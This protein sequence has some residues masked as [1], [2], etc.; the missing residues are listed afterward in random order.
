MHP[1]KMRPMSY[2]RRMSHSVAINTPPGDGI[3]DATAKGGQGGAISIAVP[4]AETFVTHTAKAY[5][6]SS[7]TAGGDV[8]ISSISNVRTKAYVKNGSGGAIMVGEADATTN[9][10]NYSKSFFGLDTASFTNYEHT[11]SGLLIRAGGIFNLSSEFRLESD[12]VDCI[13]H[14]GGILAFADADAYAN[15]NNFTISVIGSGADILADSV[16]LAAVVSKL[17]ADAYGESRAGG[18]TGKSRADAYVSIDT[19]ND[20]LVKAWIRGTSTANTLINATH[21]MDVLSSLSGFTL[22]GHKS[23]KFYGLSWGTGGSGEPGANDLKSYVDVDP[24]TTISVSPRST[25]TTPLHVVSGLGE[26]ALYVEGI[27]ITWDAN[28]NILGSANPVLEVDSTGKI[29]T[30]TDNITVKQGTTVKNQ[31]DT[32]TGAFSVEDISNGIQVRFEGRN[33]T[34]TTDA[35]LYTGINTVIRSTNSGQLSPSTATF[36]WSTHAP[37]FTFND[38]FGS[39]R[40]INGS[41][42][43][44]TVNLIDVVSSGQTNPNII[45]VMKDGSEASGTPLFRF[46]LAHIYAASTVTIHNTD[47]SHGPEIIL[48]KLINNPI[49]TTEIRNTSGDILWGSTAQII[50]TQLLILQADAGSIG[51]TTQSLALELVQSPARATSLTATAGGNVYLKI[52]GLLREEVTSFTGNLDLIQAGANVNIQLEDAVKQVAGTQG[53]GV[54]V[55]VYAPGDAYNAKHL[56]YFRPDRA[57]VASE[58]AA[59]L[60]LNGTGDTPVDSH[61]LLDNAQTS[62]SGN[63]KFWMDNA[64]LTATPNAAKV[65]LTGTT[66]ILGTGCIDVDVDGKVDLTEATGDMRVGAIRSWADDVVLTT[67][68]GSIIDALNDATSDV[69]GINLTLTSSSGIGTSANP[70]DIDSSNP[71]IGKVTASAAQSVHMIET[72]GDLNVATIT[73][74]GADVNLVTSAGSI[75]DAEDDVTSDVTGINLTLTSSSGIGISA[76]PLDIDSSNPMLGMVTAA[77]A[78]SIYLIETSSDLYIAAITSN[79]ADVTLT[80]LSGSMLDAQADPAS[81]VTGINLTF[82]SSNAIGSATNYLE[83][84]SS[85]PSSGLVK[86]SAAASIYMIET[87]GDLKLDLI[88]SSSGDVS[89]MTLSGSIVDGKSGANDSNIHAVKIDLDANGGGIGRLDLRP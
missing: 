37:L 48:N 21:G 10:T 86:A 3:T 26:L 69:I 64:V 78:Q 84:N 75:L 71:T 74:T 2:P 51:D 55:V 12:D 46:N 23:S 77:A 22:D 62:G 58:L 36:N 7:V 34:A 52:K 40:L 70:L 82:V 42:Y 33:P 66:E 49:G 24:Y 47:T 67:L 17:N 9:V 32:I 88:T 25:S 38:T 13:V 60:G 19:A 85:N 18:F 44:M 61:Y 14:G 56:F 65:Y 45:I 29:T 57:P 39:V 43:D 87:S 16:R 35:A 63:I 5:I 72:A 80:T 6:S 79:L 11:A 41:Q 81:D 20:W 31:G 4:T 30:K 83:I 53:S 59:V 1:F 73:S 89:L 68:S 15:I 8:N 76:N 54:N 28:V 50:R 27:D